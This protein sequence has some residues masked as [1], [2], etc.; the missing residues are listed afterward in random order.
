[1]KTLTSFVIATGIF[2]SA[3]QLKAQGYG[4]SQPRTAQPTQPTS[5][6]PQQSQPQKQEH[7]VV[8][9]GSD[10]T[11][12]VQQYVQAADA[13]SPDKK[14][15]V[16]HAGQDVAL[17]SLKVHE[18]RM[19]DLGGGKYVACT[20]MRG[21]DGKAYDIDFFLAGERG[22][23]KVTKTSVHKVDGNVLYSWTKKGGVWKMSQ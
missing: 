8:S 3:G 7:V 2:A 10:V 9:G 14:L 12:A 11:V 5:S 19:A 4:G 1:M 18:D 13:K 17:G 20:N 6:Q 16:K 21:G 23:L 15:H 22:N